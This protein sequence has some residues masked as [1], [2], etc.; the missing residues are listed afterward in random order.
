MGQRRLL[1]RYTGS[2]DLGWA[3][4][5]FTPIALLWVGI[6]TWTH[7]SGEAFGWQLGLAMVVLCGLSMQMSVQSDVSYT[8]VIS[9]ITTSLLPL[10]Y[11]LNIDEVIIDESEQLAAFSMLIPLIFLQGWFAKHARLRRELVESI[12]WA[13]VGI[14]IVVMLILF[15]WDGAAGLH[16]VFLDM[17][18]S[19]VLGPR[20]AE[21]LTPGVLLWGA[22]LFGYFP[23]VHARRTPA[24]PILLA[25]TLWTFSGDAADVPWLIAINTAVFAW[26]RRCDGHGWRKP[27]GG[28]RH[29][30]SGSGTLVDADVA[31]ATD[32]LLPGIVP[33]ALL[34][35]AFLGK[36]RGLCL[37]SLQW[38]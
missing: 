2:L 23:A 15:P 20:A 10:V 12:S 30:G 21:I 26:L 24:M 17:T 8:F 31:R 1:S 4:M 19:S 34:M 25:A 3:V 18:V 5:V 27:D 32:E 37:H 22:L 29:V 38:P 35:L 6:G 16:L 14:V 36:Q 33:A 7:W 13:M 28:A 9:A 11:Q